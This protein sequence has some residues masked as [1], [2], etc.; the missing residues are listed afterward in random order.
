MV[1]R[2]VVSVF[3]LVAASLFGVAAANAKAFYISGTSSRTTGGTSCSDALSVAW[4]NNPYSWGWATHQIS[5]GTTVFLCGRFQGRP[6][7]QLL[8]AHGSGTASAPIT[9]KFLPGAILSSPYWSGSGA[10]Y[11]Q[12]LSY[13]T[14]DGGGSGIIENTANGTG[15]A[16][17]QQTMAIQ[18]ASCSHCTVQNL[19][20]QNLY[21]RT[22]AY[23]TAATH[24]VNC[25]YWHLANYM[26]INNITCHDASWAIAG[27]GNN[28][29]LANSN[30]Y[31]VDHGVASGA[32]GKN[33][34]YNIHN[35]HFHDFA[36]WDSPSN[37]YHH[38]GVHLW[39]QNGGTITSGA[40]YN[41][42]FDGDFGV[43]VTAHVFLQDSVQHVAVYNNIT[44]APTYRTIN[45]IWISATSTS[46]PG[47]PATGNSANNNSINAGGQRAGSAIYADN[48][49]QFTAVNNA[50]GG[51]VSDVSIQRG[52]TFS[53]IGV[54]HNVYR[55]LLAEFGDRNTFG[56]KGQYFYSL[57]QWQHACHCD[58]SS[59]LILGIQ[60][61]AFSPVLGGAGS[62]VASSGVTSVDGAAVPDAVNLSVVSSPTTTDPEF[63]LLYSAGV[64]TGLNLS[65]LAVDELA[66]LAVGMTG[67]PR[68]ASGPWN[69]GPF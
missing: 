45:S 28:F 54:N 61:T 29:T 62:T 7:Q 33:G 1:L 60:T 44:V 47:G 42:T 69:V 63:E 50:M 43:N 51:G 23:D 24:T 16:Y 17:H 5:P 9:I 46:M 3:T 4:F 14:V 10:I 58:Y 52:T 31:H 34:G 20:I 8:V 37:T 64:G 11:L 59:S 27:D 19:T 68:P 56:F 36:N 21:V 67:V 53:S 18:A 38:D 25:V 13:I 32:S 48:Q 22:S 35:N 39:G 57:S 26:T 30:I 49:L 55:N 12:G 2:K 40:I 15:R 41:N 65:D 6:G 66:P